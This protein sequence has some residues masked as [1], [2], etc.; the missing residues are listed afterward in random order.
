MVGHLNLN[1]NKAKTLLVSTLSDLRNKIG[2]AELPLFVFKRDI[3]R[4]TRLVIWAFRCTPWSKDLFQFVRELNALADRNG[5]TFLTQYLKECLRLTMTALVRAPAKSPDKSVLVGTAQSGLPRIIP[6]SLRKEMLKG[7]S[8]VIRVVL[9]VLSVYRL[10]VIPGKLKLST[11][12]D[13]FSGLNDTLPTG[14][15][16]LLWKERFAH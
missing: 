9:T 15:V 3:W 8:S 14:E 1:M 16:S 4:Y 6:S 12:T 7:N 11:I 13:N 5:L 2:Q 10:L